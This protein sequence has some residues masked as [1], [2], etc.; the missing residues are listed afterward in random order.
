[1]SAKT[2]W[3]K[4]RITLYGFLGSLPFALLCVLFY[5]IDKGGLILPML[6]MPGALFGLAMAF[7]LR[8]YSG[9]AFFI[10]V[11]ATVEYLIAILLCSKDFDYLA[12]RRISMGG[13]GAVAFL[14]TVNAISSIRI[15]L[16]DYL[17]GFCVGI[18]TTIFIW[19][20]NFENFS[21]RFTILS[22]T[23]WQ[24]SVAAIINRRVLIAERKSDA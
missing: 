10:L 9:N 19:W 8:D 4:Y 6:Y 14:V 5:F 1:M 12:A 13:L 23:L 2:I 7:A 21:P 20:D 16:A 3:T 15:Q 22:F 17:A 11:L 24:T 18:L